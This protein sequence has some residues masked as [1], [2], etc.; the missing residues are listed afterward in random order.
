MHINEELNQILTS[1]FNEAKQRK[2]EFLT[3][4]HVLYASL[5]YETGK[6]II[7]SCG[8]DID[9]LKKSIEKHFEQEIIPKVKNAEP[10]ESLGFHS[11]LQRA[12]MHSVSAQKDDVDIGDVYVSIFEEKDSYSVYFLH[13]QNIKKID[14]LNYISHGIS[15]FLEDEIDDIDDYDLD[16]SGNR[17]AHAKTTEKKDQKDKILKLFTTELTEM[18]KNGK[19]EPLIGREDILDRT[20]RVLCRRFKNNPVHVGDPG[21]GKTAITEGLAQM[22][23]KGNVPDVLKENEVY[24]LDMAALLAGTKY[25]GDFEE[26]MKRVLGALAQ[27]E[28][29]ILFI[30]EIHTIIGAGAVSG[31]AMD[32]SNILKPAL[33]S[34]KMRCIGTTTYEEYKKYFSK[35]RALSRR[36]HKIEI[37]E[38]TAEE[39]YTILKGLK[40]KYE[41]FHNVL[42]SDGA[43][44]SA[45]ELS[46]KYINDKHLPDKA[47]DVIDEAGV[48]ARIYGKKV[49]GKSPRVSIKDIERIVS[50]SAKIPEKTVSTSEIK[51]LKNLTKELEKSIFGQDQAVEAVV[52]AIK[53][54]RAGFRDTLKPISSFLFVGP[55]GVGKTELVK[56]LA[57]VLGV[58][59][60]RFDMSEYE[61]KHTVARLIGAPPGYVG[62]DQGGMLTDAVTKEPYSIVLLDEIEKAHPDI[63]NILLQIMDYATLTDNNGKKADFRNVILIMTSNAGASLIG[64]KKMGFSEGLIS[65]EAMDKAIEKLFSPEFRNRLDSVVSFKHLDEKIILQIVK[66]AMNDFEEIL[67]PKNIKLKISK[68]VY[69]WLAKKGYSPVFG[70]REIAR[71]IEDKVKKKFVDEVLFGSLSKGGEA[72]VTLKDEEINIKVVV[73]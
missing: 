65:E 51:K 25:R 14:I 40:K 2:H 54:S 32:A 21:V 35:D 30:D 13:Q 70:A 42:Y 34:G 67:K 10:I 9:S 49:K 23:V 62:F 55:T 11:I 53:N 24:S 38:P 44:K 60:H 73:N 1:A 64:R 57:N 19:F 18:A 58:H 47:I 72:L 17:N 31:G 27:K 28:N 15:I 29:V 46:A 71:L 43:L 20:I 6:T 68:E 50:Q 12:F 48:Y 26:R 7:S 36:F 39:T 56:Q 16:E 33:M 66:K 41:D 4:E 59:L 52:Q 3:P 61:E 8:G 69:T 22:I 5:F 37:P 63:F 45:S